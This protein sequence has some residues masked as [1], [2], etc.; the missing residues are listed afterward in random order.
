[1][2]WITECDAEVEDYTP[3][4]H[5]NFPL[6]VLIFVREVS[7]KFVAEPLDRNHRSSEEG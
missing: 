5:L 1:M 4:D 6:L 2:G 3:S 7:S